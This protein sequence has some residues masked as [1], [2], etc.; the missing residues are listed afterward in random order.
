MKS[1][2]QTIVYNSFFRTLIEGTK[3]LS[4][5]GLAVLLARLLGP[6]GYGRLSFAFALTGF[7]SVVMNL[8]LQTTFVRD[9]ARD[10]NFLRENLATAILLQIIASSIIFLV[11]VGALFAFPSLRHDTLLLVVALFYTIFSII[12]NFLYSSFQAVHR[13]H[14]EAIAVG[15]QHSL[16]LI[17][18]LFLLFNQGTVEGIMFGYLGASVIGGALTLLLIKKYLFTWIWRINWHTGRA[19]LAQSWPLMAGSAL[20]TVYFSLDS[21]MLRFSQGNEA[22]G[23]YG[24]LYKIIF[25]FYLFATLYASSIFPVLSQL[26]IHARNE[27]INLYKRS[28]KLMAGLGF[29]FGLTITFF[30]RPIIQLFFGESYLAGTFALQISIWSI[31]IFLVGVILYDALIVAGK[32]KILLWS[33]VVSTTLNA[34]LNIMLIPNWGIAGAAFATVAAQVVQLMLNAYSLKTIIPLNF[35]SLIFQP[36]LMAGISISLFF[37]FSFALPPFAA[38]TFAIGGYTALLFRGRILRLQEIRQMIKVLVHRRH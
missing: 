13:M 9:G 11:L 12:T 36:T 6:E 33:V 7:A 38:A 28:V 18:V 24:A 2:F 26:F 3:A 4:G 34:L 17:F 16:L 32:Q 21:I 15:V 31:M 5:I 22:V 35:F 25:I 19:L 30:A 20:S 10:K 1:T 8:G 27:F 23:I 14:L 37:V 29:L